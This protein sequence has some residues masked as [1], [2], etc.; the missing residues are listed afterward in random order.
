M[1]AARANRRPLSTEEEED[2][3]RIRTVFAPGLVS[4]RIC[5]Q[6][7]GRKARVVE[8]ANGPVL[9]YFCMP[10]ARRVGLAARAT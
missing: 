5:A 1:T 7:K 10:C 9:T 2:A 4:C 3:V 8:I 6:Y